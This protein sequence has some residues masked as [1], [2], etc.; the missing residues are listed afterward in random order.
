M[1]KQEYE[2]LLVHAI[3]AKVC[4]MLKTVPGLFLN[5]CAAGVLEDVRLVDLDDDAV[6]NLH[7]DDA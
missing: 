3:P 1:E 7:L 4:T 2:E 5:R 6:G